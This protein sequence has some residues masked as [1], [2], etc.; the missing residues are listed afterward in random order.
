MA[1]VLPASMVFVCAL[2]R[3]WYTLQQ[4][5]RDIE[6]NRERAREELKRYQGLSL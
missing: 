6:R 5:R 2:A 4:I 1:F 3:H